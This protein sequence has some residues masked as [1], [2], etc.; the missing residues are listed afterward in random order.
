MEITNYIKIYDNVLKKETLKNFLKVCESRKE[1]LD[2]A[3]VVDSRK[4]CT[5]VDKK[6]RDVKV[7][8]LVNLK[9]KSRTNVFWANFFCFLITNYFKTYGKEI[10]MTHTN[11]QVQSIQLLKY[12]NNGHYEFHIDH[13]KQ[14]PRTFSCIFFVNENY[15]GGELCFKFPGSKE[16]SIVEKKS[17]RLIIWPSNFLYPHAVKP[18]TEG[19][20]Y[21]VVSWAL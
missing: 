6:V 13:G 8:N 11:E 15:K 14:T 10:G 7:W 18:V 20:R 3:V 5:I 4:D 19:V 17:N 21:S 1:F 9:E 12:E 2:A 16:E